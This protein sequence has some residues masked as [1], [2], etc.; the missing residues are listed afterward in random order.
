MDGLAISVPNVFTGAEGESP[1]WPWIGL[2]LALLAFLLFAASVNWWILRKSTYVRDHPVGRQLLL[3]GATGIGC[4]LIVRAFPGLGETVKEDIFKITGLAVSVVLAL[5][6]TTMV[7]NIMAG[8]MLRAVRDYR[9]GDWLRVGDQFGQVTHRGLFHVAIETEDGDSAS[10]PNLFLASQPVKVVDKK[11]GTIIS[12]ELSLSYGLRAEHVMPLLKSA[13]TAAGLDNG[14]VYVRTLGDH[15]V[16]YQVAGRL[17]DVEQLLTAR[18]R[19]REQVLTVLHGAGIEIAS[20]V[21]M[22]QRRLPDGAQIA[23]S[24]HHSASASGQRSTEEPDSPP[25]EAVIFPEGKKAGEVEDLRDEYK[26]LTESIKTLEK[27]LSQ[28]EE[29]GRTTLEGKLASS[30]RL[31]A[32]IQ[33]KLDA[34]GG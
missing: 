8:L 20:P 12:T 7:S 27:E 25:A 16:T 26:E 21:L 23:P 3:A 11:K 13:A 4:V 34:L 1:A 24:E 28:A 14:F 18:S 9:G 15:S 22:D 31:L 17:N 2:A 19:L 32:E 30:R 33:A 29:A 5:S 6:S 10:L